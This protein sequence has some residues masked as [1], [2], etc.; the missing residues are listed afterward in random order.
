MRLGIFAKTFAGTSPGPVLR[1]AVAAGYE[2]VHYNMACSGLSSLPI[3]VPNAV[4]DAVAAA[5]AETGVNIVAV[6]ATYNMV[7]PDLAVRERGRLAFEAIAAQAA[8]MGTRVLTL[9]TG[10][11][12]PTDQWR[13]HPDNDRTSTWSELLLEFGILV[14][15]AEKY[16]VVLGVEP[17]LANVVNSAG[18][19]RAL[20]DTFRSDRIKIVLDAA[21][22]FARQGPCPVAETI[23]E[24]IRLLGD[25]IVLAH[26]KDRDSDG[27]FTTVGSG[28][29][30]FHRYVSDLRAAGFE[31]TMVVHGLTASAA[32]DV[33]RYLRAAMSQGGTT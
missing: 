7:H 29:I 27:A 33:S 13:H 1:Q 31:G 5:S 22:L 6:S 32:A 17:E 25:S 9:C 20:I 30:D 23:A 24:A 12:D 26:A 21:N 15:L 11:R 4:A 28:V 2:A 8:R 10:S 19:A 16:D 18:K 14:P 3:H